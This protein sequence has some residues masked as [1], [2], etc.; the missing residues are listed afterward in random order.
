MVE[1]I[2]GGGL[3]FILEHR[4]IL[5]FHFIAER[6]CLLGALTSVDSKLKK[7]QRCQKT[8]HLQDLLV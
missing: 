8:K 3:T 2:Y 1:K 7:S 4:C 5:R 6:H